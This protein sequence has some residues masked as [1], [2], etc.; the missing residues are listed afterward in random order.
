MNPK[1][2]FVVRLSMCSE[3]MTKV[4]Q[5]IPKAYGMEVFTSTAI[6]RL[7][8]TEWPLRDKA[9]FTA[10]VGGGRWSDF[11]QRNT[12][13]INRNLCV[14]ILEVST[15]PGADFDPD[16]AFMRGWGAPHATV[17]NGMVRHEKT[18]GESGCQWCDLRVIKVLDAKE[19]TA[20]VQGKEVPWAAPLP[21]GV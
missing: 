18:R 3:S 9:I 13:P 5:I 7:L 17:E 15:A 10:R 2:Y 8:L 12:A 20:L 21:A 11:L 6:R 16:V 4:G 19:I 14:E 1:R